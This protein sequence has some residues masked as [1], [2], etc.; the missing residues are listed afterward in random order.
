MTTRSLTLVMAA[1]SG[2][3]IAPLRALSQSAAP[4]THA[5][6]APTP[7]SLA[8]LFLHSFATATPDEFD[9]IDPDPDSRTV[10]HD[11]VKRKRDRAGSLGRVVW[12]DGHRAVLLLTGTVKADNGGDVTNL[13]RHFSG[14][15]LANE[16]D[17]GWSI[18]TQLPID[19]LN[20]IHSQTLHVDLSP[21]REMSVADT[22]GV[23][24]GSP[25][26]LAMRLNNDVKLSRVRLDGDST[27]W[28]FGGGVL[29]LGATPRAHADVALEYRL[30]DENTPPPDSASAGKD[31]LPAFGAFHNTDAWHPLFGYNSANDMGSFTVTVHVPAAYRLTTTLPQVDSVA[32]GVR[33]IIGKSN[34][35]AWLLSLIYDRDWRDSSSDVDGVRFETFTTPAYNFSHDTLAFALRRIDHILGARFGGP[36]PRYIAVV[37]DR[38]IGPRGFAVRMTDAVISGSKATQLDERGIHGPGSAFAHEISHG[39]T[40][41]ATGPAANMLRE[42]WATFAESVVLRGEYGAAV[43][44]DYWNRLR[45]GYVLGSEGRR[46]IL[47]DPDNGSVHYSKGS[48]IFHMFNQLLGDSAF[49]RGLRDYVQ[50]QT[51]AKP[52]GYEEFIASMSAAAG[53]DMTSFAMPWFTQKI[54]PDVRAKVVGHRVIVSQEQNTPPFDLPLELALT[55]SS[56]KTLNRT[57]HLTQRA[58]TLD[59]G[60]ATK[61]TAV[62]V[63]P[64]HKLLLQRHWGE[65]AHFELPVAKSKGAKTVAL[66]GDFSLESVPATRVGDRW[67]V[68]LPLSEGRYVWS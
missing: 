28:A 18:A 9:Q 26:G 13:V 33:T 12:H 47:G 56:G 50:R 25:Y 65:L 37:E 34:Y 60:R 7:D 30:R 51:D 42:G 5:V 67:V 20:H 61:V 23:E 2:L 36:D 57:M 59:V 32:S 58:D 1:L 41:N 66:V 54:I 17:S 4:A 14:L 19:T 53:H 15:Y 49:D 16:T 3:V 8:A 29:W 44:N 63:D 52:A 64:H 35:P 43:E 40:M 21:G 11:A 6:Q 45:N 68:R 46:S 38:A 48:W 55:T 27:E 22:L 10:M 31:S 39:W 24:I 62:H